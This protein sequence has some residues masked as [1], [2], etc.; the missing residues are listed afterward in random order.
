MRAQAAARPRLALSLG[1]TDRR[2][3]CI[4]S[5]CPHYRKC[6]IEKVQ[7]SARQADLVIA[8]HA[9]VMSHAALGSAFESMNMIAGYDRPTRLVFDEGHHVFDAAD[10]A[11]S[12]HLTGL[13]MA[14]LR[15]WLRGPE[16]RNR[17]GRGL[18]E[19]LSGLIDDD[20]VCRELLDEVLDA[21]AALPAPGWM[22]RMQQATSGGAGEIFLAQVYAQVKARTENQGPYAVE[23]ECR[24]VGADLATAAD[25]LHGA[26]GRLSVPLKRLAERLAA[27]LDEDA[28]ELDSTERTRI[29]ALVRGVLRR[30]ALL[31]P[32]WQQMLAGLSGDPDPD[33]AEWFSIE[34]AYGNEMDVGM[35]RHWIDPTKPFA[36]SVLET[37]DGVLITSA[38]LK[39]RPPDLPDDWRNAEMR[40]GASHLAVPVARHAHASPF[41]YEANARSDRGQR[42]QP[43]GTGPGGGRLPGTV[44]GVRRRCAWAVHR[45]Y[46]PAQGL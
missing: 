10:S 36:E 15:R 42:R 40:T 11:Y 9:L 6:F 1:L 17:R 39:D 12:G 8:N 41:D 23:T 29:E 37:T 33:F 24:P 26:F 13:E 3:E 5:A 16:S 27:R 2:G 46:A 35:H 45:D 32:G 44:S 19:R 25:R 14:E 4:Y 28:D 38:T 43:R 18:T 20:Q 34:T 31:V 7:R 21:C 30:A 22:Q